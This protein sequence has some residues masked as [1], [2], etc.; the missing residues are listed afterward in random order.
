VEIGPG[1]VLC[2][3]AKQCAGNLLKTAPIEALKGPNDNRQD[4]EFVLNALGKLWLA[5]VDIDWQ[6]FYKDEDQQFNSGK[7]SVAPYPGK[8][9][10]PL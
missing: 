7:V 3:L 9:S 6:A 8:M 2:T 4:T 10:C 5:G 1:R